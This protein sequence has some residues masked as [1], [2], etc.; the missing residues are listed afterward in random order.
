MLLNASNNSLD[1][2]D[3]HLSENGLDCFKKMLDCKR[4][5]SSWLSVES[6]YMEEIVEDEENVEEDVN[7]H[8]LEYTDES[9]EVVKFFNQKCVICLELDT[10]YR[11]KQCGHQCICEKCYQNKSIIDILKCVICRT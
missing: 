11:F 2:Q 10:D 5:H 6:G 8:E 9:N 3:Y 7:I 1:P 4:I